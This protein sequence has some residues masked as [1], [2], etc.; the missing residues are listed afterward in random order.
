M[1]KIIYGFILILLAVFV[2]CEETGKE[3]LVT[4]TSK[5]ARSEKRGICFNVLYEADFAQLKNGISWAYNW[6]ASGYSDALVN[7]A[8][9]GRID[10]FPMFWDSLNIT[11]KWE[12]QIREYK[13][14][15][16]DCI[17]ILAYN[18]P[19]LTNQANMTPAQAAVQWQQVKKLA[20]EL[21]MKIVAPAMNYGTLP[22]YEDPITWMDEFFDQPGVSLDDV[23]A[24][25][26]HSYMPSPLA[27]KEYIERFRKYDKPIWLTEFSAW[28][29]NYSAEDQREFMCSMLNY[30]ESDP[31]IER[32]AWFKYDGGM[33]VTERSNS[34]LRPSG[35]RTGELTDLG[36]IYIYFS[37]FDKGLYYVQG[38][39]IPAE[40]YNNCNASEMTGTP[41]FAGGPQLKVSSDV[42]G[43]LEV[44][45]M[46]ILQWMEYQITPETAGD[47][48]L[49]FRYASE[50]G[51]KMKISSNGNE[52]REIDLSKTGSNT[53]WTTVT[54]TVPLNSG[55]Q[56][57]RIQP[58]QG[59]FSLNW[60]KYE[61]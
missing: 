16:P 45:D 55:K 58:S 15:N 3:D 42:S 60:W 18:E 32:Y 33:A 19:N 1:N 52:L 46:Y 29:G 25:A 28:E 30:L 61:K 34:K 24:L 27:V 47:Y 43:I 12:K 17:Y 22:E 51:A 23:A 57:I 2:S 13:Q 36:K 6:G 14:A 50:Y 44:A 10:Y 35:N 11:K 21:N 59:M 53:A 54:S 38:Q 26:L 40:H 31:L 8:K 5:Q 37:S 7:L 4:Y 9:E 20:Q 56:T 39:A 41:N 48:Q 49:N